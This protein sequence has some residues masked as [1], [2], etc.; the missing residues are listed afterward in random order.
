MMAEF[1]TPSSNLGVH[2][3]AHHDSEVHFRTL[4]NLI[5]GSA[6]PGLANRVLDN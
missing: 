2:I 4:D 3:D 6:A 1:A 5:G